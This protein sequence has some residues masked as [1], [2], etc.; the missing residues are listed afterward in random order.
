MLVRNPVYVEREKLCKILR[1][2]KYKQTTHYFENGVTWFRNRPR[3]CF[4]GLCTKEFGLG[5]YDNAGQKLYAT[6]EDVSEYFEFKKMS[7][8]DLNDDGGWSFE[9]FARAIENGAFDRKF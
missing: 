1:S 6:S 9:D 7:F 8:S 4:L 5:G 3:A 2:G